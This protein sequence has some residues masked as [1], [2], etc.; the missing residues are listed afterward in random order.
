MNE[1]LNSTID[2]LEKVFAGVATPSKILMCAKLLL[3]STSVGLKDMR[4]IVVTMGSVYPA[5]FNK[6]ETGGIFKILDQSDLN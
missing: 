2:Y 5:M 1:L 3:N 6:S 4:E